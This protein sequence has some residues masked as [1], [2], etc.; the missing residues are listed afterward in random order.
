MHKNRTALKL[1]LSS[2]PQGDKDFYCLYKL[3]IVYFMLN[4]YETASGFISRAVQ[5]CPK[6]FSI[7]Q[8]LL[9]KGLIYFYFLFNV[10]KGLQA[11]KD[12]PKAEQQKY[13]TSIIKSCEEALRNI[14]D[15]SMILEAKFVLLKLT[16][17]I[18]KERFG[19]D[20]CYP[21]IQSA[22]EVARTIRDID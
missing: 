17:M 19:C 4:K 9:W 18:K 1:I 14:T 10:R 20:L 13:I 22:S 15:A 21:I 7:Q 6:T 11:T 8:V 16:L 2:N 5:Y 3:A 12:K